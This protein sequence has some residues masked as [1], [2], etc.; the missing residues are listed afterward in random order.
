MYCF[1]DWLQKG[2][3]IMNF[4]VT[5]DWKLVAALGASA[6]GV[7]F[8]LKMDSNTVDHVLTKVVYACRDVA[9]GRNNVC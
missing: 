3:S 9:I 2:G 8:T 1:G 7:I 4:N 6:I 5:I